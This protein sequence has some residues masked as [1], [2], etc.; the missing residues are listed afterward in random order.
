MDRRDFLA[1][2]AAGVA[3]A[4][5]RAAA[6]ASANP[7]ASSPFIEFMTWLELA[8]AIRA[9]ATTAILPT[10][11]SEENGPHMAI[12]KH[13]TIVRYSRGRDRAPLRRGAGGA[14]PALCARGELR[15]ALGQH[16]VSRHARPFG[17]GLCGRAA[18]RSDEPE[19]RGLPPHLFRGRSRRKPADAGRGRASARP[20]LGQGGRTRRDARPLLRERPARVFAGARIF[21]RRDRPISR[22]RRARTAGAAPCPAA[23]GPEA[24]CSH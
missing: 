24:P 23:S 17:A 19:A 6:A 14:G 3:A 5:A 2:A 8:D 12:G 13:N 9:G 20:R 4:P 21:R 7:L 15:S 11:G 22:C 18:R 10:G 16:G 1:L